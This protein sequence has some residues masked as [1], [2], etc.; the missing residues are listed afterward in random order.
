LPSVKPQVQTPAPPQ[1]KEKEFL[2]KIQ[3][4][5]YAFQINARNTLI[6][7]FPVTD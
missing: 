5:P 2:L 6:C 1:K 7:V 3:K 4:F